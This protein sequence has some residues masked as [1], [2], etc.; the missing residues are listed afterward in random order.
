MMFIHYKHAHPTL[1]RHVHCYV[2]PRETEL[3]QLRSPTHLKH[4]KAKSV[5][6]MI[7]VHAMV[8]VLNS[9]SN[10]VASYIIHPV[11]ESVMIHWHSSSKRVGTVK[12][13]KAREE[14]EKIKY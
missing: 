12:V 7:A 10:S 13:R 11:T 8:H 2:S 4:S 3:I 14:S 9:Y 5:A 6:I 1:S